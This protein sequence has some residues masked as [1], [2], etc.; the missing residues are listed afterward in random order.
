MFAEMTGA[1]EKYTMKR[2]TNVHI[3]F[4]IQKSLERVWHVEKYL[5]MLDFLKKRDKTSR[6]LRNMQRQV[7]FHVYR[8]FGIIHVKCYVRLYLAFVFPKSQYENKYGLKS[9]S[10]KVAEK[11]IIQ[12]GEYIMM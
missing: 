11:N 8:S 4:I 12:I 9:D 1:N 6:L 2:Y 3:A 10:M 5:K 7:S